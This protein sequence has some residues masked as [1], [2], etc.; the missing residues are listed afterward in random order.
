MIN[1][2]NFHMR[3]AVHRSLHQQWGLRIAEYPMQRWCMHSRLMCTGQQGQW[4]RLQRRQELHH[5]RQ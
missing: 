5:W 2:S 1:L 4:N 3:P